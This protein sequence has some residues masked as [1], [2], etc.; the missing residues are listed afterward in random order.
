MAVIDTLDQFYLFTEGN[1]S[2]ELNDFIRSQIGKLWPYDVKKVPWCAA[3][4]N[5]VL[6]ANGL[7]GSYKNQPKLALTA[8][9]FLNEGTPVEDPQEGDIVILKRGNSTWQGHVSFYLKGDR[10]NNEYII[11]YG[12]NQFNPKT[13]QSDQVNK[14][15]YH[16]SKVLGYRRIV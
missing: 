3:M 2:K 6:A 1:N 8:K 10:Y 13:G 14:I 15:S 4:A 5:A 11:C 12:G 16:K 7:P 9:S